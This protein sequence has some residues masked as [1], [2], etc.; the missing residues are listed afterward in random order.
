MIFSN[1]SSH[2]NASVGRNS[3]GVSRI[4][5]TIPFLCNDVPAVV[6]FILNLFV[7]LL[8][9]K[10]NIKLTPVDVTFY[11]AKKS[12]CPVH[13]SQNNQQ[14]EMGGKYTETKC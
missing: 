10:F 14:K 11:P 13:M 6:C 5:V 3:F 7:C 1:E 2:Y 4:S 8:S 12:I 9:N